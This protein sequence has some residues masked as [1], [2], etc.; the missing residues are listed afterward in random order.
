MIIYLEHFFY[1]FLLT[2]WYLQI[3]ILFN[4]KISFFALLYW[5]MILN[6][7][8][9][10]S[11]SYHVHGFKKLLTKKWTCQV[12]IVSEVNFEL[13]VHLSANQKLWRYKSWSDKKF[14][15][16]KANKNAPLSHGVANDYNQ[17]WTFNL[18]QIGF[19]W[20]I[21]S[22]VHTRLVHRSKHCF[23]NCVSSVNLT[24]RL[25]RLG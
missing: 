4:M 3:I 13:S 19:A 16:Q 7:N 1:L 5:L 21:T 12:T 8:I 15:L 23:D 2:L 24:F 6:D 14:L 18:S 17:W 22:P 9:L 10:Y 11:C 25:I 20:N